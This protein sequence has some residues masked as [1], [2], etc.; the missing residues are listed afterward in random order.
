MSIKMILFILLILTTF[1]VYIY[2]LL[3]DFMLIFTAPS[4]ITITKA[5]K[6]IGSLILSANNVVVESVNELL[7]NPDL[8]Y[9]YQ[10]YL[11]NQITG[12]LAFTLFL[13]GI[14]YM[15]LKKTFFRKAENQ[16]TVW[17]V[18]ILFAIVIVGVFQLVSGYIITGK[19]IF[20]YSGFYTV[21]KN[22]S[23][24]AKIMENAYS[25]LNMSDIIL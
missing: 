23:E 5:L 21:I 18:T 3:Y 14:T 17:F 1:S 2:T 13:I 9:N 20:P 19:I 12:G 11:L 7:S 10:K 15:I 22:G 24:I 6:D 25:S 8:S 16:F 4:T